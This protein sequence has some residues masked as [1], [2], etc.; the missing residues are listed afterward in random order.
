MRHRTHIGA[1]NR[2]WS[3]Q[4]TVKYFT[5]DKKEQAIRDYH[6]NII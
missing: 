1:G 3:E 6:C 4:Y 2:D 5:R